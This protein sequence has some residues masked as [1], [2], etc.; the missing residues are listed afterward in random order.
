MRS[1]VVIVQ[2]RASDLQPGDVINRRGPERNGWLEVERV[3]V[4][5][6]GEMIVH[7]ETGS[8]S[9]SA[10]NYDL[11]WIQTLEELVGNGH[12]PNPAPRP[13]PD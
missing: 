3:E 10:K 9:F 4:L 13:R 12:L 7:D 5:Q 6:S 2:V 1:H 11:V 8:D